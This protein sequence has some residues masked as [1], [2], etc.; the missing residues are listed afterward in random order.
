MN[1]IRRF[2]P[3]FYFLLVLGV[4]AYSWAAQEPGMW[5]FIVAAILANLALVRTGRFRPMPRFVSGVVTLFAFFAS[6]VLLWSTREGVVTVVAD[7]LMLLHLVKLYEQRGDRDIAQTLILNVLLVVSG[8][9]ATASLWF[10]LTMAIYLV[11]AL[12]VSL[13]LYQKTELEETAAAMGRSVSLATA[14]LHAPADELQFR[15]SMVRVM[16]FLT[17]VATAVS[18]GVFI[19]F[20]RG[21]AAD[22]LG[23]PP[24]TQVAD[25]AT[26]LDDQTQVEQMVKVSQ[27]TEI[28]ARV[29][30]TLDGKPANGTQS[31]WLRGKTVDAYSGDAV[32]ASGRS[33]G[34]PWTWEA[35]LDS[36]QKESPTHTQALGDDPINPWYEPDAKDAEKSDRNFCTVTLVPTGTDILVMPGR[37]LTL[38]GASN[39]KPTPRVKFFSVDWTARS[40]MPINWVL[41]YTVTFDP[42]V[43]PPRSIVSE[44]PQQIINA[45]S[46]IDPAIKALAEDPDVCG[47]DANGV[48]LAQLCQTGAPSLDPKIGKD[49]QAVIARN[50]QDYLHDKSHYHY[51]LDMS[52][53]QK[54]LGD[55]DPIVVFLTETKRGYCE[56]FASAMTLMCQSVGV[57]ARMVF[58]YRCDEFSP[59]GGYYVVRQSDAHAWTEVLLTDEHGQ[60]VWTR[61]DPT[62]GDEV[63][64]PNTAFSAKM[65]QFLDF[66]DYKWATS[67]VTYDQPARQELVRGAVVRLHEAAGSLQS[68]LDLP[69]FAQDA[70]SW[71]IS[72]TLLATLILLM[73]LLVVGA[74]VWYAVESTRLRRRARRVGVDGLDRSDQHRLVRQLVFYDQMIVLL[75]RHNILRMPQMTPLEF[76]QS[77]WYLPPA[78]YRDI[79]RL[80]RVFYRIRYGQADIG[81]AVRGRLSDA[82]DRIESIL[83]VEKFKRPDGPGTPA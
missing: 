16:C 45:K 79:H 52:D 54:M 30:A 21:L 66:L 57:R 17:I 61:F 77:L 32:D 73:S 41:A 2:R 76:S 63:L 28:V 35:G 18:V 72:P 3:L 64:H 10:A 12:Y 47:R 37:P 5:L 4:S 69:T 24:V 56:F 13:A 42:R 83:A 53:Q 50:F 48:S 58:G 11:L 22:L 80:T 36:A 68:F 34:R 25:P 27:D 59:V 14:A 67:V 75:A 71:F 1:E 65:M 55:R 40:T 81:D 46:R 51:T 7:F 29:S 78:V 49:V 6:V 38:T 33:T 23:A 15:R 44:F 60:P 9:I 20:P 39:I 82:I 70:R 43:T 8:A 31:L 19:L 74:I 26:G 62:T